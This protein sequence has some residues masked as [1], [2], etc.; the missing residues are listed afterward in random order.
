MKLGIE[1]KIVMKS[2]EKIEL[3]LISVFFVFILFGSINCMAQ[4][5]EKE[6]LEINIDISQLEPDEWIKYGPYS[7]AKKEAWSATLTNW[8]G[9]DVINVA[10]G[11]DRELITSEYEFNDDIKGIGVSMFKP[12][13]YYFYIHNTSNNRIENITGKLRLYISK[14]PES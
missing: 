3:I 10:Y 14:Y 11:L 8:E 2:R 5:A 1:R 7:F 9:N 12:G 6:V 13:N 4:S